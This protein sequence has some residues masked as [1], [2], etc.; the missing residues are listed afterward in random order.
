MKQGL[1]RGWSAWHDNW[2]DYQHNSVFQVAGARLMQ[3]K[4][5]HAFAKWQQDRDADMAAK[6]QMTHE[7]RLQEEITAA[8]PSS[9]SARA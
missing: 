1:A 8:L 2:L 6:L 4:L 3:P 9:N 5:V 7:Q